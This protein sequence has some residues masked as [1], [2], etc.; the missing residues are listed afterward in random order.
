MPRSS[1]GAVLELVGDRGE[2]QVTAAPG[3]AVAH[4]LRQLLHPPERRRGRD[5]RQPQAGRRRPG[6]V[7]FHD[8]GRM[9]TVWP[10]WSRAR[11]PPPP[12]APKTPTGRASRHPRRWPDVDHHD[13]ATEDADARRTGGRGRR[14]RRRRPRPAGGGLLRHRRRHRP[15]SPTPPA[16]GPRAAPAGPPSTVSTRP[17]IRPGPPISRRRRLADIDAE[18]AGT[19]AAD[20]ARRSSGPV[21]VEPGEY[22]VVLEAGVR[23]HHG[24]VPGL[25]RVQRQGRSSKASRAS[26]WGRGSSIRR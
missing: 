12:C 17:T 1:A 5:L 25:L 15:P 10:P 13:P 16:S 21:D 2:A 8:H 7:G 9:P 6:G 11:W 18:A 23:R 26:G 3:P 22:E 19:A 4:P 24:G 14:L 20:R